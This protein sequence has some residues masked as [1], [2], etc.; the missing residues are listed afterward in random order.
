MRLINKRLTKVVTAMK[1]THGQ[2]LTLRADTC[3]ATAPSKAKNMNTSS[4]CGKCSND[5]GE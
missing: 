4:M 1:T 2:V 5:E 3:A